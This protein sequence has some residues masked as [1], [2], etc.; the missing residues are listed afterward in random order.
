MT[1]R[2]K[3]GILVKAMIRRY[4]MEAVPAVVARRGDPDAGAVLIKLNR[5]AQGCTVLSQ[6]R[7]PE[8][9]L[10]WMRSTGAEPVPEADADA[11]IARQ[12]KRDPDLWV[13][14]IEDPEGR[15]LFEGRIV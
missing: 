9:E 3:A 15:Q 14:E 11:Y 6:T 10:V 5:L 7:T 13:I 8:G 2:L 12:A 1:A 4:D